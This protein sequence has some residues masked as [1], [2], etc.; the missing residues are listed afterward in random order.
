MRAR[1]LPLLAAICALLAALVPSVAAAQERSNHIAARLVAEGPFKPG[2]RQWLAIAFEPEPGW[3]GY[4]L[5]PGD[6]GYGMELD[7]QLPP[8]WDVM[9][10]DYPVPQRLVIGGL[11]NH[12]YEGPYAVLT[13]L[14]VPAGA[15]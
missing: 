5:N 15:V 7:W 9:A 6:A 11:M 8:K 2:Q 14:W 1:F 10:T 13:E 3:H 4:W 12:V